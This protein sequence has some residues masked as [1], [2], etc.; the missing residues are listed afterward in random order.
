MKKSNTDIELL[1]AYVDGELSPAEK[2]YIE[3]KIKSSLEL[4][5]ELADLKET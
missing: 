5:K 1:S 2:K 3:E 4:Q